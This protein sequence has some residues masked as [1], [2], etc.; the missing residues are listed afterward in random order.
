[1]D[2]VATLVHLN[3]LPYTGCETFTGRWSAFEARGE[4]DERRVRR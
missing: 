1:M 2:M 3:G 4:I